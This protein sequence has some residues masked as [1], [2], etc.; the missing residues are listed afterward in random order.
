MSPEQAR[1]TPVDKRADIWA[2]G[3][4]LY[5]MLTGQRV[6]GGE[7]VAQTIANVINKEPAWEAL[8]PATPARIRSIVARCLVKNARQRLRD[9]GDVRLALDGAFETAASSATVTSLP[10]RGTP[11]AWVAVLTAAVLGMV[12]FAVPAV[13]HLHEAP[14]ASLP[15]T[16][17]DIATPTSDQPASFALSPDGR[18]LV[19]VA[20]GDGA[21]RLWL[22]PLATTTAQGAGGHR[23]CWRAGSILVARQPFDWRSRG[24]LAEASRSGRG[25]PD[26]AGGG[27]G[28]AWVSDEDYRQEGPRQDGPVT[29]SWDGPETTS[30]QL[31]ASG[32]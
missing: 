4:V 3:A 32:V 12:A 2:F 22:R 5:E 23:G 31:E 9:M 19:F 13:R 26:D 24:R 17:L 11:A 25:C 20:S 6:F 1:G 21:S 29:P 14:P 27:R 16:R 30:V 7:D 15:E 18:S 8:P 28:G 10:P